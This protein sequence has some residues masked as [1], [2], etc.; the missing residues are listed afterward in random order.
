MGSRS[1]PWAVLCL[2]GAGPLAAGVTQT[3]RHAIKSTGQTVTLRCSPVSGHLS[4]SWYQQ[5]L[6]QGPQ[7]L[8]EFYDQMPRAKGNVSDRF[9][10]Q[11]PN[12][13]LSEL[14]VKFSELTDSS[15]Y[16]CASS[17]AQPCGVT[18]LL[19]RN[20]PASA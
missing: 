9:S 7:F 2:L 15:L 17:L 3:P 10:V 11:Q 8:F 12:N 14:T 13:S 20:L 4:V 16:L 1:L 19:C 5:A 6:N 18:S